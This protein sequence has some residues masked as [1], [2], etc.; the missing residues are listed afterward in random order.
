MAAMDHRQQ[1]GFPNMR[2]PGRFPSSHAQILQSI[3][4]AFLG[5]FLGQFDQA[6]PQDLKQ[7][8]P[9]PPTLHAF[10]GYFTKRF[11][12]ALPQ[13]LRESKQ[14]DQPAPQACAVHSLLTGGSQQV[15]VLS[16]PEAVQRASSM[17]W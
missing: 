8:R 2:L 6:L 12:Q 9:E 3:I 14:T 7:P 15:K 13:D 11:N 16:G 4:S 5:Y 1:R 17:R 10:L